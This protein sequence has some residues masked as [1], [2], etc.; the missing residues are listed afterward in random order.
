MP[1]KRNIFDLFSNDAIEMALQTATSKRREIEDHEDLLNDLLEGRQ[2][3]QQEE[4]DSNDESSPSSSSPPQE[5]QQQ[6]LPDLEEASSVAASDEMNFF[7]NWGWLSIYMTSVLFPDSENEEFVWNSF[8]DV[9][10]FSLEFISI[11]HFVMDLQNVVCPQKLGAIL[12]DNCWTTLVQLWIAE[13]IHEKNLSFSANKCNVLLA[14]LCSI[15]EKLKEQPLP[16]IKIDIYGRKKSPYH[17]ATE[18]LNAAEEQG[19]VP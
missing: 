14:A 15:V 3:H 12:T 18:V 2:Q 5:D 1:I 7:I 6:Q 11:E 9:G 8:R 13:S 16:A 10:L 19:I 4:N 17:L